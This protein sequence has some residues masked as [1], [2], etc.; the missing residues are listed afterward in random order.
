[1]LDG[2]ATNLAAASTA[3]LVRTQT[4]GNA[5]AGDFSY[6][7]LALLTVVDHLIRLPKVLFALGGADQPRRKQSALQTPGPRFL[8]LFVLGHDL[9]AG[10]FLDD[11]DCGVDEY[12]GHDAGDE[13]VGDAVGEGHDGDGEKGRDGVAHVAPVDVCG[14]LGHEG[15]DDDESAAGSPGRDGRKDGGEEDG[16]EKAKTGH[17]GRDTGL[18]AF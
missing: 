9:A 11:V 3:P 5:R 15:T 13:A 2:T 14:G 18:S 10:R 17:H 7:T 4:L 12:V 6:R 8:E 1:M 16:D